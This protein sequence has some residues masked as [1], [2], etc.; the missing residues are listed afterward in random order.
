MR[1]DDWTAGLVG[2]ALCG[3]AAGAVVLAERVA[4][5]I[6][7]WLLSSRRRADGDDQPDR[8]GRANGGTGDPV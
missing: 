3:A 8:T 2:V 5:R 4:G 7:R 1:G 6:W